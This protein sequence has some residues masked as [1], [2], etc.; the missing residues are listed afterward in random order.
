MYKLIFS[1]KRSKTRK[2]VGYVNINFSKFVI[3]NESG[4][5]VL[6]IGMFYLCKPNKQSFSVLHFLTFALKIVLLK[7][8]LFSYRQTFFNNRQLLT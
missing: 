1:I 6:S 4:F 3:V 8:M 7:H 2:K 5:C